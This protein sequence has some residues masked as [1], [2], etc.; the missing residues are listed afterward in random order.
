MIKTDQ[1][2]VALNSDLELNVAM[3]NG[4]RNNIFKSR[5]ARRNRSA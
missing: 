1:S 4:E 3:L 2:E 5:Q